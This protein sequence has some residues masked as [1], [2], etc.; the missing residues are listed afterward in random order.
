[1][2]YFKGQLKNIYSLI[3][4]YN[5]VPWVMSTGCCSIEL[6][7]I[8]SARF[9]W[10]RMGLSSEAQS[11]NEADLLIVAGW[12]TKSYANQIK[13]DYANLRGN[14]SVIAVGAC[15]V[16]GAPYSLSGYE[17]ILASEVVPV[18]IFVPGC[19][20]RPESLL[21]A[22]QQLNELK[23]PGKDRRS[24]INAAIKTK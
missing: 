5:K 3:E 23:R 8:R 20:P 9:N 18:D 21:L 24:V 10:E 7:S 22:L 2:Q 17:P 15:A 19:P 13:K 14:K 4:S 12:I 1:M 6:E 11:S 16:S